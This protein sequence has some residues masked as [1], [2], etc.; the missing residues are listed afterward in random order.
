MA[1][2]REQTLS[3]PGI[4]CAGCAR[5]VKGA[6]SELTGV[7]STRVSVKQRTVTVRYDAEQMPLR[8]IETSLSATG[9]PVAR[10]QTGKPLPLR[11][12][13][14]Q[15]AGNHLVTGVP[16]VTRAEYARFTGRP[17]GRHQ[18]RAM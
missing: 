4:D 1:D 17:A 10:P 2:I 13:A 9:Y 8:T 5:R 18:E 12:L 14:R 11:T 3:V 7:E 15:S 6:L 16:L